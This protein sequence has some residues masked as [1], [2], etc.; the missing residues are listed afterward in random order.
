MNDGIEYA[1]LIG[2]PASSCEY[3]NKKK[4]SG[5]FRKRTIIKKVNDELAAPASGHETA[6]CSP[7]SKICESCP[8]DVCSDEPKKEKLSGAD[9][10]SKKERRL[11]AVITAQVVAAFALVAA[12]LLTNI[13][14]ADSGMNTLIRTVFSGES[15]NEKIADER[16]FSDFSLN[17][18]VKSEGVTLV[19]G[20][21]TVNGEYSVY[22]VCEGT[23][24]KVE[25]AQDGTYSVTVRHSDN[26][27]SVIEGADL[28]YF[29]AGDAVNRSVPVCHTKKEARVYLYEKGTLLTDYVTV[30][31]SIVFNK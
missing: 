13:F 9:A 11:N 5:L 27:S 30:E 25:K 28:V 17:L 31:D 23:V 20:V 19:E 26:F 22:P 12:I 10:G 24:E 15:V 21:I 7:T 2:A 3:V 8:S 18:P 4:R 16:V 14:W 29:S 1:R 6:E